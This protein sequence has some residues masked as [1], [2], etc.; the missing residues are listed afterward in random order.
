ML[1]NPKYIDNNF[2]I[3]Y[4]E[5]L[6][7]TKQGKYFFKSNLRND[8]MD[9]VFLKFSNIEVSS[10]TQYLDNFTKVKKIRHD[11]IIQY[12]DIFEIDEAIWAYSVVEIMK[13]ANLG[14]LD[15]YLKQ[16]RNFGVIINIFQQILNGYAFLHKN[17][18]LHRDVKP[19]NILLLDNGGY[20]PVVKICD[21]EFWEPD[22][23]LGTK[24]TPEYLAP[25]VINFKDY[26]VQSEIWAIGIMIYE[27]FTGQYPFGTRTKGLSTQ[28]IATN[29]KNSE[30]LVFDTIPYPFNRIA[31]QAL[32]K[33]LNFRAKSLKPLQDL[34]KPRSILWC[35]FKARILDFYT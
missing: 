5:L 6:N 3:K 12:I 8:N 18:I 11:N 27:L 7:L 4:N 32:N 14:S 24:S 35:K 30:P 29:I 2:H 26:T 31:Q 20:S 25:E 15:K 13:Y 16:P 19:T 28:K 21:I 23:G 34:L 1:F 22:D 33:D 9:Q 17:D 10:R